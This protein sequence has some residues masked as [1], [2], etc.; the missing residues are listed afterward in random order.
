MKIPI[1][2][3]EEIKKLIPHKEP[4]IMVDSLLSCS[5]EKAITGLKIEPANLLVEG[6]QLSEAGL[7]EHMAQSIALQGGFLAHENSSE[8]SKIGYIISIKSAKIY[9][10]PKIN[11]TINSSVCKIHEIAG[12]TNSVVVVKNEQEQLLAE[13]EIKTYEQKSGN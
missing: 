6:N 5:S 4:F 1:H 12:M 9:Q 13:A 3:L 10:L 8:E 11:S 7:L 2:T